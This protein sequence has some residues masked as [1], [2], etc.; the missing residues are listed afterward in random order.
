MQDLSAEIQDD[1]TFYLIVRLQ[2]DGSDV[3]FV[4]AT[5]VDAQGVVSDE[6]VVFVSPTP[7]PA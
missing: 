1:G 4:T 7:P 5:T 3:G 2:T 6:A